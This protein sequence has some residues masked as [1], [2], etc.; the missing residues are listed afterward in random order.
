MYGYE[1]VYE[2]KGNRPMFDQMKMLGSLMKNAGAIRE[3]AEQMK[4][5]LENKAVEGESG[6]GAVRITMNGKGR[7][8]RVDLEANLLKGLAGDDKVI[9][10]ELI[11]AAVNSA[12]EK[13]Q[14]LVQEEVKKAAGGLEIPGLENMLPR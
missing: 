1:Y 2:K 14:Q 7:V 10:E 3:R 9:V 8:V 5:E 12:A 11:A 13:V 6:G 4:A